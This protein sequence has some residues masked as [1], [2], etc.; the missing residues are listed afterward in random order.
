VLDKGYRTLTVVSALFYASV[1]LFLTINLS[2]ML[3]PLPVEMI[4][5]MSY[6]VNGSLILV[7]CCLIMLHCSINLCNMYSLFEL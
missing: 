5:I 6:L 1:D 2:Q 3:L 7:F 4:L